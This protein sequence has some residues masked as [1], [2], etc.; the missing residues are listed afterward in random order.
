MRH[1]TDD[2]RLRRFMK[3]VGCEARSEARVYFTGGA[4]AILGELTMRA[5]YTIFVYTV[6]V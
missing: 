5:M 1:L 4:S 6:F 2:Q 3:A